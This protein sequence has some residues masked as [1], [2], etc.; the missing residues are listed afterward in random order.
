MMREDTA[1]SLK[2][3]RCRIDS[4]SEFLGDLRALQE[5]FGVR[6]VLM[7]AE[8]M[9]GRIH[10]R[11]ALDQALRAEEEQA[12]T[13]RS[14]EMEVLLYASGQRQTGVAMKF[15][16][17]EGEM[18]AWVAVIP[19]SAPVWEELES[20]ISIIPD[21]DEIPDRRIPVLKELFGIT[22]PELEAVGRRRIAELVVERTALLNVLK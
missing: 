3:G 19:D 21:E 6:I 2:L 10:A 22:D 7:D 4:V 15:G 17:H 18:T 12:M 16:L 1:W 14:L 11:A 13:A 5:R 20:R 9:A 8:L